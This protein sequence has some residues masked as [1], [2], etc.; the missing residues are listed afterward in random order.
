M[1]DIQ[2]D[3]I[4]YLAMFLFLCMSTVTLAETE[5][6]ISKK[7]RFGGMTK[8]INYSDQDDNYKA[9]INQVIEYSGSHGNKRKI[10]I[11]TSKEH[12]QKLDLDMII[13]YN[14]TVRVVELF[15]SDEETGGLGVSKLALYYNRTNKLKKKEFYFTKVSPLSKL[16]IYKR[17]IYYDETGRVNRVEH[18]NKLDMKVMAQ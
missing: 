8:K 9:G 1:K 18:L 11:Y 3:V 4:A 10:E 6:V 5:V 15:S 13:H 14:S 7:N 16:G 12:S 17:V 2:I